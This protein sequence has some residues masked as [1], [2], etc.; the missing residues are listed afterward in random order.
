MENQDKKIQEMQML[1]QNLQ[2]LLLQKQAF[3]MELS[4]TQAAL[5][6]LEGS[7]D[8]V[9]KIVGQLMIKTDK[10]KAKK[11]LF[12]KEKILDLRMKTIEKQENNLTKQL[13]VLREEFM[14]VMKK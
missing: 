8:D 11:E 4:E 5:K 9:F 7:K 14:K 13:E 10:S 2:N 6:E 3:Q 12:D 1:E